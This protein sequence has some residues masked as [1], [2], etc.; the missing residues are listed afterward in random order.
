LLEPR[1]TWQQRWLRWQLV[2]P[3]ATHGASGDTDLGLCMVDSAEQQAVVEVG[4]VVGQRHRAWHRLRPCGRKRASRNIVAL[5]ELGAGP[6]ETLPALRRPQAA[7]RS[8]W[9]CKPTPQPQPEPMDVSVEH[10]QCANGLANDSAEDACAAACVQGAEGRA[11][12]PAEE[13]CEQDTLTED[14]GHTTTSDCSVH[15]GGD[16]PQRYSMTSGLKKLTMIGLL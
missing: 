8:S 14:V 10:A 16:K 4:G 9:R 3:C 1:A 5:W 11:D 7:Q 13:S 6:E 2:P 12:D 15:D